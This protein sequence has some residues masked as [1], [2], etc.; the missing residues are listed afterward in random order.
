MIW[1]LRPLTGE[2][3]VGQWSP[4]FDKAFGFV[5][6]AEDETE[7]RALASLMAGDEGFSSWLDKTLTGCAPLEVAGKSDVIMRDFRAA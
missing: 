2:N 5:V 1:L 6:R 3:E 4:W 7:A